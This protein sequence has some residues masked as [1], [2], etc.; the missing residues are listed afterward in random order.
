[1]RKY[2]I[3]S[4]A[5]EAEADAYAVV[6]APSGEILSQHESTAEAQTAVRRYES[7]EAKRR[8]LKGLR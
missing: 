2:K 7:A 6:H 1:M 8:Y 4:N 5:A 3:V